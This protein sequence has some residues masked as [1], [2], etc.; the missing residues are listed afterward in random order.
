MLYQ[1]N[2]NCECSKYQDIKTMTFEEITQ[3]S[4][5]KNKAYWKE[6]II[7]DKEKSWEC[8][9]HKIYRKTELYDKLANTWDLPKYDWLLNHPY[10]GQNNSTYNKLLMLPD[11]INKLQIKDVVTF[12]YG[13]EGNQ[14]TTSIAKLIHKLVM[15]D[16]SVQYVDFSEMVSQIE[17]DTFENNNTDY[18]IIDN[19]FEQ[20]ITNFKKP[21][22]IFYNL[23]LKRK[24]PVI[25]I[26][27][28]SREVILSS[29]SEPWK[30]AELLSKLFNRIDKYKT[31]LHFTDN[32]EKNTMMSELLNGKDLFSI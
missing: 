29:D 8:S 32:V 1:R 24:N 31:S 30:N 3:A 10:Q 14:K 4:T 13:S 21:Y 19:C 2:P 28:Y 22:T 17:K 7:Y 23:I 11:Q 16:L 6:G 26:S 12:V 18:L 9:C 27:N 25:L 20:S 5:M 15:Q